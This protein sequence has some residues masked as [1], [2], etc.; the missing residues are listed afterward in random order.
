MSITAKVTGSALVWE[1]LQKK[2]DETSDPFAVGF[3]LTK[4]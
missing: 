1:C 3:G 4:V 2:E